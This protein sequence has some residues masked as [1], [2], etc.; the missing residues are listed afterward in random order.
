MKEIR[1]PL[2]QLPKV[3]TTETWDWESDEEC[4]NP[5]RGKSGRDPF[6]APDPS[7]IG[8]WKGHPCEAYAQEF[9][10]LPKIRLFMERFYPDEDSS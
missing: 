6:R 4:V 8:Q 9:V 10:S 3:S 5:L 1:V 7:S 2:S